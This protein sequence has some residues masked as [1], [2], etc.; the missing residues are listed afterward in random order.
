LKET[1]KHFL[2][3]FD[4]IR[5]INEKYKHPRIQ[6]TPMVR[7]SLFALRVYL[8]FIMVILLIK[9]IRMATGGQ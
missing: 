4:A 5:R 7:I 2:G 3:I 8:V 1:I 6:M 9:F